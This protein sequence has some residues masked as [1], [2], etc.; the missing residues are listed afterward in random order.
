MAADCGC[1]DPI[2]FGHGCTTF[3]TLDC[4]GHTRNTAAVTWRII[5]HYVPVIT[6]GLI[7]AVSVT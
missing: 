5:W 3:D 2:V 1:A 6:D 7:T 4:Y